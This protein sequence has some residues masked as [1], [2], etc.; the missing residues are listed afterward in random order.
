MKK[1]FNITENKYQFQLTDLVALFTIV[2]VALI[3]AGCFVIASIFGLINCVIS[4]YVLVKSR[5]YINGYIIQIALLAL[6]I[7]FLVK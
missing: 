1:F 7:Y 5:G 6:N 2:N 4:F 3:M